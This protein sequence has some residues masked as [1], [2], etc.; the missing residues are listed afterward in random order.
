MNFF[1]NLCTADIHNLEENSS[2]LTVFTNEKGGILDD[3]IVTKINEEFLYVVSNAAMK[4]QDQHIMLQGLV[5]MLT[6][7]SIIDVN[8]YIYYF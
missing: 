5:S 7:F 6:K 3:L 2:V 1:E 8:I 4:I